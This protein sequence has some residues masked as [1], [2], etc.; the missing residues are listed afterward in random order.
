MRKV[1]DGIFDHARGVVRV[2]RWSSRCGRA[3]GGGIA[4]G[5]G[6]RSGRIDRVM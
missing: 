3:A 6:V 4:D 5:A 2:E 1:I